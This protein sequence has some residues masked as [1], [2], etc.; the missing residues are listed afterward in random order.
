MIACYSTLF[1]VG[2]I[3]NITMLLILLRKQKLSHYA[4]TRV[5]CNANDAL[6]VLTSVADVR[7]TLQHEYRRP[8]RSTLLHS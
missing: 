5:R 2:L 3:G 4:R 7:A 8:V 6:K 1:V